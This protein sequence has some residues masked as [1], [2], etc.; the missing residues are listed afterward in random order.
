MFVLFVIHHI[1]NRKWIAGV[2][3]GKYTA[4]RVLQSSLV[5]A[6]F[7][8]MIGSAVS[9]IILSKHVFAFLDQVHGICPCRGVLVK[10]RYHKAACVLARSAEV[11]DR[12]IE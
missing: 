4:F 2:F 6:L 8:T 5:C 9:G 3:R 10:R 11:R 12:F 7:V 1:L